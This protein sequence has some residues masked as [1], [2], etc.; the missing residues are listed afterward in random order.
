MDEQTRKII[1]AFAK[2]KANVDVDPDEIVLARKV[3]TPEGVEKYDQPIGTI[4]TK[5]MIEKAA[6]KA[7]QAASDSIKKDLGGSSKGAASSSGSSSPSS[8]T[9]AAPSVTPSGKPNAPVKGTSGVPGGQTSA[10]IKQFFVSG[11]VN[12]P[13]EANIGWVEKNDGQWFMQ[14]YANGK[15][16]SETPLDPQ[17]QKAVEVMAD[18]G[19]V[20]PGFIPDP[21]PES[22]EKTL[23]KQI[24][25]AFDQGKTPSDPD[26]KAMIQKLASKGEKPAEEAG[27]TDSSDAKPKSEAKEAPKSEAKTVEIN[28]KQVKVGRYSRPKGF[29]KA[30]LIVNEDGTIEYEDKKGNRKKIT[31]KSFENHQSL[32]MDK[33][34]TSDTG[35]IKKDEHFEN[36]KLVKDGASASAP[37]PAKVAPMK[38]P[39]AA[40]KPAPAAEKPAQETPKAAP[41]EEPKAE[42]KPAATQDSEPKTVKIGNLTVKPGRYARPKGFAKAFLIVHADGTAEY[43][44]KK[45]ERKKIG[46]KSFEGHWKL[47]MNKF[48]TSDTGAMKKG[49]SYEDG[50]L[51]E[52][53]NDSKPEPVAPAQP[54]SKPSAVLEAAKQAAAALKA[55][56]EAKPEGPGVDFMI[57]GKKVDTLPAGTKVYHNAAYKSEETGLKYAKSPD[58]KWYIGDIA[59][60][61]EMTG[62]VA[63]KSA[64]QK[65]ANGTFVE[66]GKK[67]AVSAAKPA[68]K[69]KKVILGAGPA[70]TEVDVPEDSEVYVSESNADSSTA[71]VIFFKE[72]GEWVK[73]GVYSGKSKPSMNVDVEIKEGA[74]K[75]WKKYSKAEMAVQDKLNTDSGKAAP[76]TDAKTK[77]MS[78]VSAIDGKSTVDYDIPEDAKIFVPKNKADTPN[79]TTAYVKEDG[80]WYSYTHLSGKKPM[81]G[82]NKI[83]DDYV[84]S[85]KYKEWKGAAKGKKIG[86]G[87]GE[88][89]QT[90]EIFDGDKVYVTSNVNGTDKV[91]SAFVK[92]PNGE[93]WKLG[94]T[95][96]FNQQSDQAV[97]ALNDLSSGD[98]PALVEWDKYKT[99]EVEDKT[100]GS[101]YVMIK[102]AK[103]APF[104]KG[105]KVYYMP[106]LTED[107]A[108]VKFVQ[109][110]NGKWSAVTASGAQDATDAEAEA[111]QNALNSN[112]FKQETTS[113][114]NG[115]LTP[116][117]DGTQADPLVTDADKAVEKNSAASTSAAPVTSV[118]IS[119]MDIK[120]GK[121]SIGKG[122]AK[123][124]LLVHSDGKV[125]YQN[126]A[127]D[128]KKLTPAAF[129]KNWDAGMNKYA[130]PLDGAEAGT[131]PAVKPNAPATNLAGPKVGSY[132]FMPFGQ[133]FEKKSVLEVLSDG[134]SF[135]TIPGSGA[136]GVPADADGTLS[137][138]KSGMVVD[139]YGNS[140]VLPGLP[141]PDKVHFFGATEGVSL[142]VLKELRDKL[143]SGDPGIMTLVKNA[144][145]KD[146]DVNKFFAY[147]KAH[148]PA[149]E[150]GSVRKSFIKAIDEML[151]AG[152]TSQTE[153]ASVAAIP[154]PSK[155]GVFK[156]D[157]N[158]FAIMPEAINTQTNFNWM[159]ASEQNIVIKQVSA[160]LGENKAIALNPSKLSGY[161]KSDWWGFLMK[162]DF[163][164]MY[165]LESNSGMKVSDAHPGSPLNKD[166]HKISWAP[167]VPGELPAGKKPAGSWT[168]DAYYMTKEEIDNYLI[169]ANMAYP[170]YLSSSNKKNWV[171]YHMVGNKSATDKLSLQAKKNHDADP[172]GK[173][174]DT[175]TWTE[176]VKPKKAYTEYIEQ[177]YQASEWSGSAIQ[178]YVEDF[179]DSVPDADK[180]K[181]Y[182]LQAKNIQNYLDTKAAEIA[183]KEAAEA[184]EALKPKFQK[185][186]G[187]SVSGGHHEA[188]VLKDQ[189]D[190]KW[191]YKP[192][193]DKNIFLADVEQAAHELAQ[194]WGF[195]TSKSFIT[196]FDGRKGHVQE[197]FDAEKDLS[198]VSMS[199]LTPAQVTDLAKE[200]LLD[201]ALDNDDS[202]GANVL[203]LKN[204]SLVGIDK[205]RAFA[206]IGHWNGLSAD[207][208][209]HVH[210]PL[211][212]TDLYKAIQSKTISQ[213]VA[214]DAYFAVLKQAKKMQALS[215]ARMTEKLEMAFANRTNWFAGG[216]QNKEEAIKAALER[217]NSLVKDME[218]LWGNVFKK[219]GYEKPEPPENIVTN[220]EDQD[221]HLGFTPAALDAAK[222]SQSYGTA[223]FFAGPEIEDSHVLLF[224]TKTKSGRGML[225]AE[226]K[227]REETKA[228]KKVEKWLKDKAVKVG[229]AYGFTPQSMKPELPNE[230]DYYTKIIAGV[231]T[232]SAHALDGQYNEGSL[233]GMSWV[234][235]TLQ[236]FVNEYDTKMGNPN[237]QADLVKQYKDPQAFH[238]MAQKYLGYI[239]AAEAHKANGTKSA[240]GE[241][242]QYVW[243]PPKE[244]KP[245]NPVGTEIKVELRSATSAKAAI[246]GAPEMDEDGGLTHKHGFTGDGNPG[247]MYLVTLPTGETIEFRGNTTGTPAASKGLVRWRTAADG[248]EAASLERIRVQMEAMGLDMKE[249]SEDDLEL[250]YWRHLG[251]IMDNRAD[252]KSSPTVSFKNTPKYKKFQSEK[253]VEVAN[254]S[255]AE[256]LEAWK[257]A[258]ANITSRE[259]IDEFVGSGGHLPKFGHYQMKQPEL[260]SGP[261]YWERFDVTDEEWQSKALPSGSFYQN[262]HAQ[263]AVMT[264]GMM[265]TETRLRT[266]GMWKDN[267]SSAEDQGKGSSQFVFIRQNLGPESAGSDASLQHIFYSPKILK[268]THNYSFAN[269]NFGDYALKSSQSYFDFEEMTKHKGGGNEVMVKH[270]VS[271]LDDIE[272]VTF[273]DPALRNKIIKSLKDMGL[274]EIRGVPVEMRFV[275]RN[276]KDVLA[277]QKA[278]KE[279][280]KK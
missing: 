222:V 49:D 54:E 13:S 237:T 77:K 31:A 255:A 79:L 272:I 250:Y 20:T 2:M 239:S 179:P 82:Y 12:N 246:H 176:G 206:N 192:R 68:V 126:K 253:P 177:G 173:W 165:L 146:V 182:Y 46:P 107:K 263:Y 187:Q 140:V 138:F 96:G 149:P 66:E 80:N 208:S 5:D 23:T 275:M 38:T 265:A 220:S 188:M 249:A 103:V 244:D 180:G 97:K 203:M 92:K 48:L 170:E 19:F 37:E 278:A 160:Q 99:P 218:T 238:E 101:F 28:G 226:F 62:D 45:G 209:A 86:L 190:K 113:E 44:N 264:G 135:F 73:Q 191:V 91:K 39:E 200:H 35:P 227:I 53:K 117:D 24:T 114:Q 63:K 148:Y 243:T 30:F 161:A 194:A 262:E 109:E 7:S 270:S 123:A 74:L 104:P 61:S 152:N 142:D 100:D 10:D 280:W 58:G 147:Q 90:A 4:I 230:Q 274:D 111:A 50:K 216:P 235:N 9:P 276:K 25:D 95:T 245:D 210:M 136:Q 241:F 56:Q 271:M 269:D 27:A 229:N 151:H 234:K 130:G 155:D 60:V 67:E 211:V 75:P 132:D 65:V 153:K 78:L 43:E 217:K 131:Q 34:L 32:G 124:F 175:P 51:V 42:T 256:E 202:W 110:P 137:T 129:K 167:A 181:D 223:A 98:D 106:H 6:K 154:T 120:P 118:K 164:K 258:F 8:S 11:G 119:G 224:H 116:G 59:G 52:D 205:G 143:A 84:D 115:K 186:P 159:S 133:Q 261:P 266:L 69:T 219:A 85:G 195:K 71:K 166:T 156:Y 88:D 40:P 163:Q 93:W 197:M 172:N 21:E 231:K 233:N 127:G 128:K 55:K 242:T 257:N 18:K 112:L 72:N 174:S 94:I 193:D 240:P 47:G 89:R 183:A 157:S 83:M 225:N 134:S 150:A 105:T 139:K 277:A 214:N 70:A 196:E 171:S 207:S 57:K 41:V 247:S 204:G 279:A 215:D 122:F 141:K 254:M 22:E 26:V 199:E 260:Y 102:G 3:R 36:G 108:P 185:A 87:T 252:A 236:N 125:E 145:G 168:Y 14:K 259:Q 228:F 273:T 212:Y 201:W 81:A 162:G 267:M 121:Y 213:D 169:A 76:K 29:A 33:F 178:Q 248:N 16:V 221:V 268:R 64:N 1:E 144:V 15:I 198:S 17:Q 189:F 184:A 158:G 232:I 251:N